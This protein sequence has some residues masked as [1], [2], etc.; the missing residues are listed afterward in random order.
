LPA[1]RIDLPTPASYRFAV[2]PIRQKRRE[3][4]MAQSKAP[5]WFMVVAVLAL[6]WNLFGVMAYV[7][8]VTMTPEALGAL[9]EGQRALMEGRPSWATAA[10]AIAVNCGALG[11]LFLVLKKKWATPLL[12]LSLVGVLAQSTY[13]FLLADALSVIGTGGLVL[14]V[15]IL[16]IAIYLVTLSRSAEAKGWIS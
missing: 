4:I 2:N 6:L 15:A 12:I 5:L 8:E 7:G 10:Y 1:N 14:A 13:N 9:S 11:G 16:V 3:N